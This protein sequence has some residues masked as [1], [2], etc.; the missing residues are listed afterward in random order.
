MNNIWLPLLFIL[1]I[2]V[3]TIALQRI[4]TALYQRKLK[5]TIVRMDKYVEELK[6]K[7][8]IK[9]TLRTIRSNVRCKKPYF[10][11]RKNTRGKR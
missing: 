1:A 7:K 2:V 6:A 11:S 4:R 5:K 10:C 3:L 8:H 9:S